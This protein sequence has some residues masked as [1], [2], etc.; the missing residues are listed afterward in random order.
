[1]L[2]HNDVVC[3]EHGNC[4]DHGTKILT[5]S[6]KKPE[7]RECDMS[8]IDVSLDDFDLFSNFN[9]VHFVDDAHNHSLAYMASVLESKII[10]A[11]APRLLIK[12]PDCM[13]AF[14][15]N[16]LMEDSF[17]RFKARKMNITQP[18]KST[19]DIC[20]FVDTFLKFCENK[21]FSFQSIT[22]QV[23]QKIPFETLYP[24]TKFEQHSDSGHR[25]EFV[26]KIIEIYMK[27]KS[28][29]TAKCITLKA[30]EEAPIRHDYKK[31][32]QNAGQ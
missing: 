31:K 28:I 14:I 21:A 7:K 6:S 18:C 27:L 16:E 5:V 9:A 4:I 25:Y 15:E 12:C 8:Y 26:K 32:I 13:N 19:Y 10:K 20:K 11:K 1:M 30:H 23:L 2:I 3:S 24:S 22:M 29:H 17:I